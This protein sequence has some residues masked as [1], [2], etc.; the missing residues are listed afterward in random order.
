MAKYNK[1]RDLKVFK[2][3]IWSL[4]QNLFEKVGRETLFCRGNSLHSLMFPISLLEENDNFGRKNLVF[5][6]DAKRNRFISFI[7]HLLLI[8]VNIA[9]FS[10]IDR[11]GIK[12]FLHNIWRIFRIV[13]IRHSNNIFETGVYHM[14]EN[15]TYII[16]TKEL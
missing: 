16:W 5:F 6:H 11:D 15:S 10:R 1:I 8:F 3:N 12:K 14:Q 4:Y 9:F 13:K 7:T 2:T